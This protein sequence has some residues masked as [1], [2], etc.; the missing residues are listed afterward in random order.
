MELIELFPYILPACALICFI[1]LL[2]A[3]LRAHQP[4]DGTL[5]WIE[6]ECSPAVFKVPEVTPTWKTVIMAIVCIIIAL[7]LRICLGGFAFAPDAL[8]D[9]AFFA[10]IC[11]SAYLAA[12]FCFGRVFPAF[13]SFAVCAALGLFTGDVGS[14]AAALYIMFVF[15]A[16]SRPLFSIAGGIFLG[17]AVYFSFG[18][19]AFVVFG[20]LAAITALCA[21]KKASHI[22]CFILFEVLLPCAVYTGLCFVL[23]GKFIFPELSLSIAQPS[24]MVYAYAALAVIVF[25]FALVFK[26]LAGVVIFEGIAVT[27]AAKILGLSDSV[28]T[29]SLLPCLFASIV[30]VRGKKGHKASSIVLAVV[31]F[32][33]IALELNKSLGFVEIADLTSIFYN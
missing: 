20:L 32:A 22:V 21:S 27:I 7:G 23:D 33:I 17:I 19:A 10:I 12:F 14:A 1:W 11:L 29:I 6:R 26:S 25:I 3:A 13:V 5:E 16:L 28:V 9:A 2:I 18:N 15:M 31:F 30:S 4:A 24:Y 8:F